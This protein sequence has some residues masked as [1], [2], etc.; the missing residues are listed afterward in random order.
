[1]DEITAPRRSSIH[2]STTQHRRSSFGT[3]DVPLSAYFSSLAVDL[4]QLTLY[5]RVSQ[6]L[7]EWIEKSKEDFA[8]DDEDALQVTP[9]LF[10]EY[11]MAD[12]EGRRE[13]FVSCCFLI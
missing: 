7:Q 8:A 5:N 3:A 11:A 2:P 10:R 12:E 9:E 1:M 13:L 6:E 4:P